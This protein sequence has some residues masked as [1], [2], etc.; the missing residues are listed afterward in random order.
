LRQISTSRSAQDT[1]EPSAQIVISCHSPPCASGASF[2][3][4][5]RSGGAMLICHGFQ[6]GPRAAPQKISA[7]PSS[8]KNAVV[9][10]KKP[11]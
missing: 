1:K 3:P 5:F 2:R 8:A 6:V 10:P 11:T 4:Y 9:T 7:V